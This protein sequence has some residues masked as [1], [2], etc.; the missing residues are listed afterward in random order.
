[1]NAHIVIPHRSHFTWKQTTLVIRQDF[2]GLQLSMLNL[3]GIVVWRERERYCWGKISRAFYKFRTASSILFNSDMKFTCRTISLTETVK[4]RSQDM[5]LL[6]GVGSGGTIRRR[7]PCSIWP[8]NWKRK[9]VRLVT[10]VLIQTTETWKAVML[11]MNKVK[12]TVMGE[13]HEQN[14][15]SHNHRLQLKNRTFIPSI[16]VPSAG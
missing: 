6:C 12:W 14:V 1:M 4:R 10:S 5:G 9:A 15:W 2:A 8:R 11:L 13:D 3:P 16:L 7:S